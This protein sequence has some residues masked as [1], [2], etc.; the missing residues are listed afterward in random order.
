MDNRRGLLKRSAGVGAASIGLLA[1]INKASAADAGK[2]I[3]VGSALP[4]SGIAAADGVEY[5]NGLTLAAEEI[6]AAGGILGRPIQ[7]HIEDTGNMGPV[8]TTQAMQRL[9]D[10]YNV[11][12]IING[13][14]DA[15]N[16]A[17]M[18]TAADADIIFSHYNT[19]LSANTKFNSNPKKY[20]GCF[21]GCPPE[22]YY[23]VGLLVY[24]KTLMDEKR[25]T[26]ANRKIA[27][28]PSSV[29]YAIVIANAIRDKAKDFGWEVSLFET[30]P[31]PNNQWGPTLAK[32]RQDTPGVIAV[33]HPLP[34][35]LAQFALQFTPQPTNSLLYMQYGP[36]L[37]AF[38]QIGGKAT[39]GVIYS[40]LIGCVPDEFS[41]QF[42][43]DYTQKFGP[44]STYLTG[45]QTYDA[46]WKWA[47]S[48][49]IAGGPGEPYQKAQA[50]KIAQVMRQLVY[51]G[52]SGTSR[53]DPDGQSAYCY[54]TQTPDPSLGM[55]HQFL[56]VQ[57]AT[58][59]PALI[60]PD[61]YAQAK[62]VTP[63]WMS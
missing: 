61:L 29:E 14:N 35:D 49:A 26:P 32:I 8:L 7:L 41:E 5:R 54:P 16:M 10:R 63:P 51:R 43:H 57:D 11:P 19:L 18:D 62:F 45:S 53:V 34:Q 2:P 52:T 39:T 50:Q 47:L 60:A 28:I 37:P 24:L 13:Y 21:Q 48:A 59:T 40:T 30:V 36:S 33:T 56:Q 15:T 17:E 1:G 6:N 27:I 3:P 46:L 58:K 22:Y 25:W 9:I 44:N 12:A 42:R 20:Y 31:F 55:P 4:L 38:R 23:G